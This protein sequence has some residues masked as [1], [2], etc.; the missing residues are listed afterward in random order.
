MLKRHGRYEY[1]P[2]TER[3]DYSWS[4]GKRLAVYITLTAE[5]FAFGEGMG[6]EL[7]PR[8]SNQDVLNY[9]WREYGNRVGVWRLLELFNQM[10][11]PVGLLVN[12]SIYNECPQVPAAFRD[13]GDEIIA[14]G[15][16]NS[17]R[18]DGFNRQEEEAM[19]RKVTQSIADHE[20][21]PPTGWL[22]PWISESVYTPDILK[23]V[24]YEYLLDWCHDDQPIWLKTDAGPLLSVPYPQEVNDMTAI[25][26]RKAS[27]AEFADMIVDNF[28]EMLTQSS[29]QPLVYG[30]SLHSYIMGQPFRLRHLRRA[31]HHII[32]NRDKVWLTYPRAIADFVASE[33]AVGI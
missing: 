15:R 8:A 21:K 31:F 13:R 18:Q 11:L 25:A 30:I 10:R 6:P 12:S 27:A 26:M 33:L 2:I 22:S 3:S 9:A 32:T 20:S 28:D 29:G 14:H 19:I 1:S 23:A 7:V 16:T 17:E 24:G 5:S 4:Y